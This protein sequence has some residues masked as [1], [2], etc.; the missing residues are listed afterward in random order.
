MQLLEVP[1]KEGYVWFRQGIWLFR[2]NPLAFLMLLFIYLIAA[3]LAIFVPLFGVIALLVATPGLS[4]GIMT[5]CREVIQNKRVLPTVLLAG[6][7]T[8]G[9]QATRHLLVLGGIYACLVFVL[10]L[11]AGA[12]VNVSDL[13]PIL[14]KEEAPS[15]EAVRQMYYALVVG[16]VLYT[17]IAMMFWFAPLLAA[18]HNVP[19]VKAMFFS[20]TAC[21]R[22]RGAFFTYALLFAVLM[23]AIPFFLEAVFSAFGAETVLSF[24]VTPYSL[25][26]L[27]I[28]YCSFYATYRGCFNVPPAEAPPSA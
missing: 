7:R 9:K 15:A 4:V 23:V 13:L 2:K 17:P 22:N 18:W 1:A 3:Q 20:W 27:A 6:F 21:W 24:L 8:N 19:P 10:S 26:M 14:L 12:V 5:A 28:L 25:L 16:A 11:I